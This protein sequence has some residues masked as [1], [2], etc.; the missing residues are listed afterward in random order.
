M[1]LL[2]LSSKV[3]VM[4]MQW[5]PIGGLSITYVQAEIKQPQHHTFFSW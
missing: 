1:S 5:R 4:L 3:I 2:R